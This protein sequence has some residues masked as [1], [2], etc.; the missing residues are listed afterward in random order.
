[1]R[2]ELCKVT[3]W[4]GKLVIKTPNNNTNIILLLPLFIYLLLKWWVKMDT[5]ENPFGDK[6]IIDPWAF[7]HHENMKT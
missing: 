4:Q 1:M 6:G 3:T 7:L 5:I 2:T